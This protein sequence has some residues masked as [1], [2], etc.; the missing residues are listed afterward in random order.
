MNDEQR[1]STILVG[2]RDN[3]LKPMAREI[4]QSTESNSQKI[5]EQNKEMFQNITERLNELI[6]ENSKLRAELAEKEELK[7]KEF[8]QACMETT[9]EK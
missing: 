4:E 7:Q 3:L 8:L 5:L 9:W 6:Q 2:I 1:A